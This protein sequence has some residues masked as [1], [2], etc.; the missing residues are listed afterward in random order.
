MFVTRSIISDCDK[1]RLSILEDYDN[2]VMLKLRFPNEEVKVW[3][4]DEWLFN[5]MYPRLKKNKKKY[6]KLK[7]I[8]REDYPELLLMFEKAFEL[9][10]FDK[11]K[12]ILK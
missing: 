3:D 5:Q 11:T 2:S 9:G 10:F 7:P 12:I 1:Y 8:P 4:N 6:K